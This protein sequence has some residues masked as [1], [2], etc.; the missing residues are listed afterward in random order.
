MLK[1]IL[2]PLNESMQKDF[3]QRR[4]VACNDPGF[5]N[6]II[7]N[8]TKFKLA[9]S[10][11]KHFEHS[12]TRENQSRSSSHNQR[13]Y[14]GASAGGRIN[15]NN[16]PQR[17]CNTL[18]D[19]R[20]EDRERSADVTTNRRH[21]ISRSIVDVLNK[22]TNDNV[23]HLLSKILQN[24]VFKQITD[25]D[26]TTVT[27][28]LIAKSEFHPQYSAVYSKA[29]QILSEFD[30]RIKDIFK[31]RLIE[32]TSELLQS[33]LMQHSVD[34]LR[35]MNKVVAYMNFDQVG[36]VHFNNKIITSSVKMLHDDQNIELA[37]KILKA[38]L[39]THLGCHV[40]NNE[41]LDILITKLNNKRYLLDLSP[42]CKFMAIDI[43][44]ALLSHVAIP[45]RF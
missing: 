39:V 42:K 45:K 36:L 7:D 14:H 34:S 5:V 12:F 20:H 38:L 31:S 30:T 21:S 16:Y 22:C 15:G 3:M 11:K 13:H 35:F 23:G 32:K 10:C 40:L 1:M 18:F 2:S 4:E 43:H 29:A 33:F 8:V 17:R 19:T 27:N 37:L 28:T 9:N 44:N 24:R 41:N 25:A 26:I 6:K